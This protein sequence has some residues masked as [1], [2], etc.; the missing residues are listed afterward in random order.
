MAV[1]WRGRGEAYILCSPVSRAAGESWI[2]ISHVGIINCEVQFSLLH[3]EII[4]SMRV[5]YRS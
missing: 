1:P 3:A 4:W 5:V 2:F